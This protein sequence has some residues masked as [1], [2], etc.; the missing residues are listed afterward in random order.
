MKSLI[1]LR[2]YRRPL[3]L[4]TAHSALY[5]LIHFNQMIRIATKTAASERSS[6]LAIEIVT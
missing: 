5:R 6:D 3:A 4:P 2:L 1:L